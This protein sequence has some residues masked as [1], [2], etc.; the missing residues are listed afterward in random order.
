[1]GRR[2]RRE[3]NERRKG[4]RVSANELERGFVNAAEKREEEKERR[5]GREERR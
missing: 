3:L 2:R 5:G 4:A 1:M